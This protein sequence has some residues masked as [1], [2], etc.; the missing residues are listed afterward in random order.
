M[1]RVTTI[2][3]QKRTTDVGKDTEKEH[4]YTVGGG[5]KFNPLWKASIAILKGLKVPIFNP[6][7]Q[8]HYWHIPRRT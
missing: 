2:K 1:I 5:E 4:L 3:S 7:I 8:S 6:A